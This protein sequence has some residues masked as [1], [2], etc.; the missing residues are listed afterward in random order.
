MLIESD[1][2]ESAEVLVV[3]EPMILDSDL[4]N[5]NRRKRN[6]DENEVPPTVPQ[7]RRRKKLR[8]RK[9]PKVESEEQMTTVESIVLIEQLP[10]SGVP[11]KENLGRIKTLRAKTTKIKHLPQSPLASG[12]KLRRRKKT[13]TNSS[14]KL[15]TELR[16]NP[17]KRYYNLEEEPTKFRRNYAEMPDSGEFISTKLRKFKGKSGTRRREG[18]AKAQARKPKIEP[19]EKEEDEESKNEKTEAPKINTTNIILPPATSVNSTNDSVKAGA[20]A[21]AVEAAFKSDNDKDKDDEED[22]GK[23]KEKEEDKGKEKEEEKEKNNEREEKEAEVPNEETH[24]TPPSHEEDKKDPYPVL[25]VNSNSDGS[26]VP[27]KPP[28][29]ESVPRENNFKVQL[30]IFSALALCVARVLL[31]VWCCGQLVAAIPFLLGLCFT[32]RC[33]FLIRLMLDALFIVILFIYTITVIA[34]TAILRIFVDEMTSDVVFEWLIFGAILAFA[35]LVYIV[36]FA[37]VLRCCELVLNEKT[38]NYKE[39][40]SKSLLY[41]EIG[42]EQLLEAADDV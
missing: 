23:D 20:I 27:N 30:K 35:L 42:S 40:R 26:L 33:L 6:I 39:K 15:D 12:K 4:E 10:L 31:D 36:I 37:I 24:T 32:S 11:D 34:F 28:G 41:T 38:K 25:V 19:E 16:R 5:I 7:L 3:D 18:L 22:K 9:K 29:F 17:E 2:D 14:E 13:R 8:K 1:G 21:K